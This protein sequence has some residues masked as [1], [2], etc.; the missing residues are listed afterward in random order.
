MEKK[1]SNSKAAAYLKKNGY[2]IIMIACI[3]AIVTMITIAAIASNK[4]GVTPP[5]DGNIVD[6]GPDTN[7]PVEK[8]DDKDPTDD[9]KPDEKLTF[10][11]P[12]AN[13][14]T[15]ME[16]SMDNLVFHKTLNNWQVH[17]GLDFLTET[18]ESVFAIA[19]G[20]IAEVTS[21]DGVGG[22]IVINHAEGY[23]SVYK[24]LDKASLNLKAGDKVKKGDEIGKTSTSMILEVN[25]G[26]HLHLEVKKDGNLID[27]ATLLPIENK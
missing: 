16:F 10:T 21:N 9:P 27:P 15:N 24:S 14:V 4:Q 12:V 2:Y 20:T 1:F 11:L 17:R 13:V 26:N 3:V 6:T 18:S 19:D 8:P 22:M 7:I 25:E 23:V 5:D